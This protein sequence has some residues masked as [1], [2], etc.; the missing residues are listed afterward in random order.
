MKA[1]SSDELLTLLEVLSDVYKKT[2]VVYVSGSDREIVDDKGADLLRLIRS[3]SSELV[4]RIG[5]PF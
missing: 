3:V 2:S 5:L 4:S 1:L